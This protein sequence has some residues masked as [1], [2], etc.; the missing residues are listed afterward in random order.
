MDVILLIYALVVFALQINYFQSLTGK[1]IAK[2]LSK[3]WNA[4]V[5]IDRTEITFFNRL[6]LDELIIKDRLSDS[7]LY[8][9][10]T[11]IGLELN[12]FKSRKF[13]IQSIC[14]SDPK[15][16]LKREG[17]K[18]D[19]NF[20]FLIDY[21]SS[22]DTISPPLK[23]GIDHF[24][25]INGHF[26]MNDETKK[27]K[28][29][30]SFDPSHLAIR[31]LN[32]Y[33]NDLQI[34]SN[35]YQVNYIKL[36]MKE[37]DFQLDNLTASISASDKGINIHDLHIQSPKSEVHAYIDLKTDNWQSYQNPLSDVNFKIRFLP[38]DM[39]TTDLAYFVPDLRGMRD[40]PEVKG[41]FSGSVDRL[42]GK[43]VQLSLADHSRV[44]LDFKLQ[45][46][47]DFEETFI[48]MDV[49]NLYTSKRGVEKIKIPPFEQN[50]Y[51]QLP[52]NFGRLGRVNFSGKV[53]GFPRNLVVNGKIRTAIGQINTDLELKADSTFAYSGRIAAIDFNAGRFLDVEDRLGNVNLEAE[54][55]GQ[56][57][58]KDDV[59]AHLS[60]NILSMYFNQYNYRNVALS[61]DFVKETFTG[62]IGIRD[63]YVDLDFIG[64]IDL[65]EEDY[66]F[67]F[68][69]KINHIYPKIVL[70]ANQVDSTAH[71]QA[72][73]NIDMRY[74]NIDSLF[75][76]FI[77][78]DLVY[79]DFEDTISVSNFTF[80]SR[81]DGPIKHHSIRSDILD[82]NLDGR[83]D[84]LDGYKTVK[85]LLKTYVPN[86]IDEDIQVDKDF[87]FS[88][89]MKDYSLLE[90]M[91]SPGLSVDSGT[92][93]QGWFKSKDDNFELNSQIIGFRKDNIKVDSTDLKLWAD[94]DKLS[95]KSKISRYA[96][97]KSTQD[98]Y[99]DISSVVK[100]NRIENEM[101][102]YGSG[103]FSSQIYL[104]NYVFDHNT[105]GFRFLDTEF[106]AD[107]L[108]WMMHDSNY[109]L[110]DS[111]SWS[112]QNFQVSRGNQSIG[113]NGRISRNSWDK[114]ELALD[115]FNLNQLNPFVEEAKVSLE[116]N[117]TG[118]ASLT[119]VYN[120]RLFE[121]NLS[122][123]ELR[124]NEKFLGS[125]H[126]ISNW[127]E[128][129]KRL[130]VD[131]EISHKGVD[132]ID[133]NGYYSTR[134]KDSPLNFE[135]A[136]IDLPLNVLEPFT[137]DILSEFG[138]SA[139]GQF[140]LTGTL[141]EPNLQG[142]MFLQNAE[143]LVEYTNVHY[144]F[145]NSVLLG[146]MI[147]VKINSDSISIPNFKLVDKFENTGQG[148]VY[149]IH[150][151][152]KT[153]RTEL[154]IK[155]DKLFV[156]NTKKT[157]NDLYYGKAVISGDVYIESE[158]GKSYLDMDIVA[159][160]KTVFSLPMVDKSEVT[161]N[162]FVV[163]TTRE[164]DE[165][166]IVEEKEKT[167]DVTLDMRLEISPKAMVRLVF[168]E[169]EQDVVEAKG[170]G[171]LN[172]HYDPK[173][174]LSLQGEYTLNSGN[175]VFRLQS[176]VNKRFIIEPGSKIK[177]NGD[178]YRGEMNLV[179][180]YK[181]RARLIDILPEIYSDVN[182][183]RNI[184]VHLQLKMTQTI[185]E[186]VIGFEV[187]LPESNENVRQ[188]L[189]AELSDETCLNQQVFAL[190]IL[191][192]FYPCENFE[193]SPTTAAGR[194]TAFEAM[195]NQLSGWLSNINENVDVGISYTPG[196]EG[197]TPDQL[198]VAVSTQLFNDRV[199]LDGNVSSGNQTQSNPDQVAGEGSIEYLIRPDGKL[200]V[201]VFNKVNER[202]YIEND[203]LYIQ[204][205]GLKWVHDFGGNKAKGTRKEEEEI[206]EEEV[207]DE[208]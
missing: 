70:A 53:A 124:F 173:N 74:T 153:F 79:K 179:T 46:L 106:K 147:P 148:S 192:S 135:L 207:I 9:R 197:E 190:L 40:I 154:R 165:E 68:N 161:E 146:D 137:K 199:V 88:L 143:A 90:K 182:Y 101:T 157:D 110:F 131:G 64:K 158:K 166:I 91:I 22:S 103:P 77:V 69:S 196:E 87:S 100:D 1:A 167:F 50:N 32:L 155:S 41:E 176:V 111:S 113:I 42:N 139:T 133:F 21:F 206:L 105:V 171:V 67:N 152:F 13:S 174:S 97:G 200:S 52:E 34:D 23:L 194:E 62:S 156:M 31:E 126:I 160:E 122:F 204:G 43:D 38:S 29:G 102:S 19:F 11:D 89:N 109:V 198:E 58:S 164:E 123:M 118:Y 73:L 24:E 177:W 149:F 107:S 138:G 80:N 17:E 4:Y 82:F 188:Q 186:P 205:V 141:S 169:F 94:G 134:K 140:E 95:L 86:A 202:A 92:Y 151:G 184:P 26:N 59:D 163:F 201:K 168:D 191:T 128:E 96:I 65:S 189:R 71:I 25:I 45:G 119:D 44:S 120:E 121:S 172:M 12:L 129:D 117:I 66:V 47:P 78:D 125:G 145:K 55:E 3:E 63:K 108:I 16:N 99:I 115:S 203:D 56:G 81:R 195:S 48:Y 136:L 5:D 162:E 85:K 36:S 116:G 159:E 142:N 208:E 51:I 132:K 104:E 83:Y 15:I 180:T 193:N 37:Q 187:Y 76:S 178:P 49:K 35:L 185:E 18:E 112:F 57:L 114:I 7:L 2:Y 84:M 20:K 14:L 30:N 60:G 93:A 130:D 183:K 170:S 72:S 33:V 61:G 28:S 6:V 175:Y 27:Q 144:K 8:S 54:I 181:T 39:S 150:N 98:R 75:G 127:N 10:E